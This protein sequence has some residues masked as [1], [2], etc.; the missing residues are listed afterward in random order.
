MDFIRS[1]MSI[2]AIS[3]QLETEKVMA[4]VHATTTM[5]Y[6]GFKRYATKKRVSHH[7][8]YNP[9][10]GKVRLISESI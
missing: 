3:A 6:E 1:E 2:K 10:G 8:G 4:E 7:Q 5:T 9:R